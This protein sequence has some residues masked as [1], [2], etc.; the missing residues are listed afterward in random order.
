MEAEVEKKQLIL[1]IDNIS[2]QLFTM[3]QENLNIEK[4]K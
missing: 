3:Y 1:N 2:S 4:K